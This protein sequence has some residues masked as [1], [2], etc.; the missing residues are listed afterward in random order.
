MRKM[1]RVISSFLCL[2][3]LLTVAFSTVFVSNAEN[4]ITYNTKVSELVNQDD[5]TPSGFDTSV[6]PYDIMGDGEQTTIFS[7]QRIFLSEN[8]RNFIKFRTG[9]R[10][11]KDKISTNTFNLQY[12]PTV[13]EEQI[14]NEKW[15]H[16][17][18]LYTQC[19]AF[20]S[21]GDGDRESVAYLGLRDMHNVLWYYNTETNFI[22]NEVVVETAWDGVDDI[23][24]VY[25]AQSFFDITAGD[26]DGDHIE[27]VL[28]AIQGECDNHNRPVIY[29][30]KLVNKAF[31]RINGDY[32]SY[33]NQA[34]LNNSIVQSDDYEDLLS[35]KM[36]TGDF[37]QFIQWG[38]KI[39]FQCFFVHT[40]IPTNYSLSFSLFENSS[41]TPVT[42]SLSF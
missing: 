17:N 18:T 10:L 16:N 2:T 14:Y 26:F 32:S 40:F 22:E 15:H 28:V 34:Y 7:N 27:T 23:D 41:I 6:D 5:V 30:Y 8:N 31:Q 13:Y 4:T 39:N 24:Y 19:V 9:V 29:E 12:V 25:R 20:D 38:I 37:I 21:D 35:I 11:Q 3:T 1:N 42:T 36:A 33:L